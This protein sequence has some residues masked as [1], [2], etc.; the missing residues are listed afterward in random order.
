MPPLPVVTLYG[1]AY[2]AHRSG[3]FSRSVTVG[4][5]QVY[6]RDYRAYIG[7]EAVIADFLEPD[8]SEFIQAM[9]WRK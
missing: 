8:D 5:V 1:I 3:G 2:F 7:K 6:A 4:G 9:N